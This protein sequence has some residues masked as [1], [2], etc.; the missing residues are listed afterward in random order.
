MNY[1]TQ[2]RIMTSTLSI[3]RHYDIAGN[4]KGCHS[5]QKNCLHFYIFYL[6]KKSI[7]L[8]VVKEYVLLNRWKNV[9]FGVFG[10]FKNQKRIV[11][12]GLPAKKDCST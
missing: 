8:I 1:V 10:S 2:K 6:P 11:G 5:I 12:L 4:L 3:G 9:R 7:Q